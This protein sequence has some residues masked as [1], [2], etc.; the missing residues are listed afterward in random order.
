M[1]S[2]RTYSGTLIDNMSRMRLHD[3]HMFTMFV[4]DCKRNS[5]FVI[6]VLHV[7]KVKY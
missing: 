7:I 3:Y 4:D 5:N 6:G 2:F 1:D